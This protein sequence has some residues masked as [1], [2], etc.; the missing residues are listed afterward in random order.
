MDLR[1]AGTGAAKRHPWETARL[2]AIQ[3]LLAPVSLR[4][5]S[6]LDVGCG[7]GFVA[8]GLFGAAGCK[9]TAVDMNLSDEW[10]S[11]LRAKHPGIAFQKE[12]PQGESFDLVL[13]LDVLEHVEDDASFLHRI[14]EEQLAAGGKVAI[15]VPAF[16]SLYCSHDACL[17]HF[18]RYRLQGLERL[19]RSC[20][21]RVIASGHFFSSLVVPK[22]LLCKLFDTG[23]GRGIGNWRGGPRLTSFLER[24]LLLDNRMLAAAGRIGIKIPG[25]TAWALCEKG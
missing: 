25:L 2:E 13:L 7:D 18:R 16:P 12:L 5:I 8:A 10:L 3:G 11:R 19:T 20:R 1:E 6:V 17:G 24:T 23:A 15:T 4:G 22:L 9:V 14:V 21:L